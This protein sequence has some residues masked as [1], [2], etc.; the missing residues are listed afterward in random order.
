MKLISAILALILLLV[1][2]QK[3]PTANYWSKSPTE[4][5]WT[6]DTLEIS[7][8]D[9]TLMSA[10]WGNSPNNIF[11]TGFNSSSRASVFIFDGKSWSEIASQG[12]AVTD[13]I[14]IE[15]VYGFSGHDVWFGGAN[16]YLDTTPTSEIEKDSA[17]VL[18]YNGIAW[19][20]IPIN[21]RG[22]GGVSIA[23]IWGANPSDIWFAGYSAEIYHWNGS[24][25]KRILLPENIDI[26]YPG[27]RSTPSWVTGI[28]GEVV[29]FSIARFELDYRRNELWRLTNNKWKK[30][31]EPDIKLR[32]IWM[33]PDRTLYRWGSL[34]EI[35]DG[36]D[37]TRTRLPGLSGVSGPGDNALI[38][39]DWRGRV[40]SYKYEV[41]QEIE[42]LRLE[43]LDYSAVWYDGFEAFVLAWQ[44]GKTVV[45]HGK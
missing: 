15:A 19:Q 36:S 3:N 23:S 34:L 18:H 13:S 29:Y 35:F 6:S 43:D 28:G 25:V 11:V 14:S 40:Y 38:A 41:L 37:W 5:T 16:L 24:S 8:V 27:S 45:F 7:G 2:C 21:G 12:G 17:V 1:A 33:S 20:R 31:T 4:Y 26:P 44:N 30:L 10:I 39:P 9:Q 32:Q 42:A 22:E